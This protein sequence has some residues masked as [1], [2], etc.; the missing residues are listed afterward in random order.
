M[1]KSQDQYWTAAHTGAILVF[2][3]TTSAMFNTI[4]RAED[5]A[6]KILSHWPSHDTLVFLTEN[7]IDRDSK[8]LM[9]SGEYTIDWDKAED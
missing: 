5:M 7:R 1:E 3:A 6:D 8:R 4:K 9:A 2:G